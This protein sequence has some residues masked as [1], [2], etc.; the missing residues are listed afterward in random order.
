MKIRIAAVLIIALALMMMTISGNVSAM[1]D[2]I[3]VNDPTGDVFASGD[4]LDDVVDKVDIVYLRLRYVSF[5]YYVELQVNADIEKNYDGT[6]YIYTYIITM[7]F[8]GDDTEDVTVTY[9]IPAI[10]GIMVTYN[11]GTGMGLLDPSEWSIED[12]NTLSIGL[13][14][15]YMGGFSENLDMAAG[16]SVSN[17]TSFVTATDGVEY[18]YTPSGDDD[19]DTSDDD[20]S[21]D[22]T[23]DDDTSGNETDDDGDSTPGFG[24]AVIASAVMIAVVVL[25]RR[26]RN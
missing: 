18:E 17:S 9:T 7:D 11:E 20:T 23:S 13:K 5:P 12:G 8:D 16:T 26:K 4:G 19:D 24:I 15:E 25:V 6:E 14:E 1:D 21:D 10:G 22:D 2:Q 3:T